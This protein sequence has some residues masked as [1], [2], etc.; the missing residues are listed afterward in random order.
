[1]GD[2]PIARYANGMRALLVANPKATT[3]SVRAQEV[4]GRA[5][6][7]ELALETVRTRHRGH[8]TVLA[9]QAAHDEY[10]VV[11]A[12][13]GDGT[14]NE[15]VNGLLDCGATRADRPALAVVPGGDANVFARAL[16][17][18]RDP[19]EATGALLCALRAG[20]TRAVG[21]GR[22]DER[23]FTFCAGL[24]FDAEVIR[25]VEGLRAAGRRSSPALYMATALRH[26]FAVTD[27]RRPA[28]RLVRTGRP[29]VERLFLGVISNTTPWTFLGKHPVDPSPQ[30][31]FDAGLDV[32]AL[33]SLGTLSMANQIRQMLARDRQGARG[34]HTVTLHD[35][36]E[37]SMLCTRPTA[38]QVD[39]D[40]VGEREYVHFRSVPNAL[41]VVINM[42]SVPGRTT[43]L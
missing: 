3:V 8:A 25:A 30:A 23:Y 26:Y 43:R 37:F 32:F 14:V 22:A 19:V 41:R 20:R 38:L 40:Y 1:M 6:S 11:V 34:R 35:V 16:G 27:R 15:V 31:S 4:I 29:P 9:Q 2:E 33:R 28:L 21:L 17:L 5:L 7:S 13:G 36:A 10:D 24:G 42:E 39:G 12:L 18:P